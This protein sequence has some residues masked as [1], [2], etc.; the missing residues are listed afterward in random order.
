[1]AKIAEVQEVAVGLLKPYANNAKI[2][3]DE[4][5]EKICRSIRE[6]GFI[7]PCLIDREYNVIAGHGRIM[8]AKRLGMEQVPCLF[9]EGLTDE[10]RKAYIL[11]D[12][13]LTELGEWDMDLVQ[14]ELVELDLA[15]FDV[16]ITGFELET[17]QTDQ[18][19]IEQDEI[20]ALEEETT[21]VP[22]DVFVLGRHRVIC[23]DSTDQEIIARLLNGEHPDTY[24]VDPPYELED[25]YAVVPEN[26]GGRLFVFSDHKHWQ[27]AVMEP[28]KKNWTSRFEFV[29]DCCQSWYTP[30]R[31]LARH[32]TCYVWGDQE[33]W[34]FD[35]AIIHDGKV[36][37]EKD[38]RNTRGD[39]HYVP[40]DGA[41]HMRTVEQF[42]NTAQ[43]DT[44]GYGKPVPW[45]AAMLNGYGGNAVLDFFGGS[46]AVL[47]ACE[48]IGIPCFECELDPHYVDLIV[49]RWEHHTNKKA[50]KI[51][52][53]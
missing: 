13:R 22:G 51:P 48:Q 15:D 38:V 37:E 36:R 49:K 52:A 5:V 45:L 50:E 40:L 3:G 31:P 39:C 46:G 1:M 6:F 24:F 25:L 41:V 26:D 7:S 34:E 32:K 33:K 18:D 4:Q 53:P 27:R 20:P 14:A 23:G 2:H 43:N 12:N 17:D 47:I 35:R 28:A 19:N 42:P 8:A 9:V 29:W 16:S 44:N 30:N 10:Q 21:T 11:A